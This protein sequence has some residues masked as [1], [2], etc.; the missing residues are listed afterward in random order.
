MYISKD[1]KRNKV[2][3]S[4]KIFTINNMRSWFASMRIIIII[5]YSICVRAVKEF[6]RR[7]RISR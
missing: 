3:H 4:I 7:Y 5:Y 1:T 2:K 6:G